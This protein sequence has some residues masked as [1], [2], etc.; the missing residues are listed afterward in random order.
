MTKIIKL[1][2][3]GLVDNGHHRPP[4]LVPTG[5]TVIGRG[6]FLKVGCVNKFNVHLQKFKMYKCYVWYIPYSTN[7][8]K[9]FQ[10]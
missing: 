2:D 7:N 1:L 8:A 4:F 6:D 10:I 9:L 3:L 5:V